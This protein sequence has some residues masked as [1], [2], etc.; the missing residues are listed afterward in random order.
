MPEVRFE[1][2]LAPEVPEDREQDERGEDD[3]D[4][5]KRELRKARDAGGSTCGDRV[6]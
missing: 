5:L 3:E 2:R 1:E 6:R 4:G